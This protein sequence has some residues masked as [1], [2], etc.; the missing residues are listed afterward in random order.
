MSRS[1]TVS[2][3]TLEQI[4][5]AALEQVRRGDLTPISLTKREWLLLCAVADLTGL[6][7]STVHG[8]PEKV[9]GIPVIDPFHP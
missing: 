7:R 5:D 8:H 6:S 4:R 3:R 9:C 1:H 2:D